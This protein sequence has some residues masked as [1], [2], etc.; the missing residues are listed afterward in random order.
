[1]I[2]QG[3]LAQ[4]HSKF[5]LLQNLYSGGTLGR[6]VANHISAAN[7]SSHNVPTLLQHH[8][9]PDNNCAIWDTAYA[10]EYDGL[11]ARPA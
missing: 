2:Q 11:A 10:R 8:S 5:L 1:M 9:L 7:L 4:G 3:H 6:I